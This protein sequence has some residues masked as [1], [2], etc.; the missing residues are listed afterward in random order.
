MMLI[1]EHPSGVLYQHQVGGNVCHQA[2]LEGV[3]APLDLSSSS[4]ERIAGCSFGM[5]GVT[6]EVAD[7]IDS[8]L[9]SDSEGKYV[10]VDRERLDASWEAWIHV[11]IQSPVSPVQDATP[12]FFGSWYGFGP[13]RAVLVWP[14]SD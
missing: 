13:A 2:M 4:I 6:V 7:V 11:I 10:K 8:I 5:R 14:N 3:L 12:S 1:I 9:A